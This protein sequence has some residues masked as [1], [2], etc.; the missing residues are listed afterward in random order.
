MLELLDNGKFK[1]KI[2]DEGMREELVTYNELLDL[3]A[4][5]MSDQP[6]DGGEGSTRFEAIKNHR[7]SPTDRSKWEVLVSWDTGEETW[8]PLTV[9]RTQDPV[10]C[11]AYAKET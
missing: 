6:D 9:I 7:R 4:H 10:T 1:L 5:D 3:L 2:G 8:E 11:A